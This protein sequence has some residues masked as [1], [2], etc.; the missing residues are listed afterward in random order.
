MVGVSQSSDTFPSW[1]PKNLTDSQGV[2]EESALFNFRR[3]LQQGSEFCK[4]DELGAAP[5]FGSI[6]GG[7]RLKARIWTCEV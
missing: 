2:D 5:R 1:K 7:Y 6:Y 3:I 4:L